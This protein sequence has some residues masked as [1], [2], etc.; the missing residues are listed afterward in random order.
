MKILVGVKS[1][2]KDMVGGCH[3]AIRETWGKS[4]PEGVDLRFFM[5]G[6]TPALPLPA[7]EILL[8]GLDD[9]YWVLWP[10]VKKALE[11]SIEGGYDFSF[12][13]D[14]D[15]YLVPSKWRYCGFDDFDFS[16]RLSAPTMTIGEVYPRKNLDNGEF[17]DPF[18]AY[19]SG[20]VGYFVSRRAAEVIVA[21][22]KYRQSEDVA[23]GQVLGPLIVEGKMTAAHLPN[24]EGQGAFH[25]CCGHFGGGHHGDQRKDPAVAM[26]EMHKRI[27]GETA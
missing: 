6:L 21:D 20:G 23:M 13:C 12:L 2:Q 16:G 1:C 25:L 15:T 8:S 3:D 7:D 26:R 18:Y 22:T 11:Y 24:L 5:G 19:M 10:K 27:T 4:L 9:T 17:A 14:T